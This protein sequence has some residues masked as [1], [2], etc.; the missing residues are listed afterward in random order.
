M[1]V[2]PPTN[3]PPAQRLF[4]GLQIPGDQ[5]I[6]LAVISN[7][8]S[9]QFT[10]AAGQRHL[11]E[12]DGTG[13]RHPP[14]CGGLDTIPYHITLQFLGPVDVSQVAAL[15]MALEA[16]SAARPPFVLRLRECHTFPDRSGLVPKIA[17]AGV[18]GQRHQ[19][20]LLQR[21]VSK[22]M[23]ELGYE[24]PEYHFLPHVTVGRFDTD[25]REWCLEMSDCWRNMPFAPTKAFLVDEI[26]LY[27]SERDGD[28]RV[29]YVIQDRWQ[30]N[31]LLLH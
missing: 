31:S 11:W 22:A 2:E 20:N 30:L 1:E 25:E 28:G 4:V 14:D 19:L 13:H 21:A 26:G 7:V 27:A 8:M 17:W 9:A 18:G 5:A 3:G 10:G 6:N 12:P 23:G 15:K 24:P 29:T 16:V